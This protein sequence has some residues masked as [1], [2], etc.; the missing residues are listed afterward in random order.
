MLMFMV[1]SFVAEGLSQHSCCSSL[2]FRHGLEQLL[3][4]V[5]KEQLGEST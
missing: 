5:D 1:M 2:I 3:S 4:P